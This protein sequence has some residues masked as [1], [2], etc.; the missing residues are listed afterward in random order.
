MRYHMF[1]ALRNIR[2][3]ATIPA[4]VVM[5]IIFFSDALRSFAV[6][7][8]P[9]GVSNEALLQTQSKTKKAGPAY[10]G[11]I[12][13]SYGNLPLSFEVNI[14]QADKS[15]KFITRGNGY[16]LFLTSTEAVLSLGHG[17]AEKTPLPRAVISPVSSI[18][19]GTMRLLISAFP[20]ISRPKLNSDLLKS[21]ATNGCLSWH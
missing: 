19:S 18:D 21:P 16:W 1:D 11:F 8:R 3:V 12:K 17:P 2:L 13:R 9:G 15:V 4:T 10:R 6:D 20:Q 14:G 7:Y 5:L